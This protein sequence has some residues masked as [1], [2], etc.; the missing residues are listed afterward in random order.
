MI[1]FDEIGRAYGFE[2]EDYVCTVDSDTWKLFSETVQ[3]VDWDIIDGEFTPLKVPEDIH[4]REKVLARESERHSLYT[5]ADEQISLCDNYI[6]LGVDTEYYSNLK[7]E[8]LQ[9]KMSVRKTV[10][11]E[12]FPFEVTYPDKLDED[13]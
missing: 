6:L 8:W 12:T 4:Y 7:I 13:E 11:Q 10:E 2:I 9:Y 1:Y 5:D 3:G